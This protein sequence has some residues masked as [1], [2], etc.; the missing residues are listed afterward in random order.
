MSTKISKK[1]V[2]QGQKQAK[3]H[4]HNEITSLRQQ[5]AEFPKN[6]SKV[7]KLN[8]LRTS[9]GIFKHHGRNTYKIRFK[10]GGGVT[11]TQQLTIVAHTARQYGSGE[12]HLT[13]RQEIEILNIPLENTPGALE[14]LQKHGLDISRHDNNILNITTSEDAGT[15]YQEKFDTIPHVLTLNRILNNKSES[16]LSPI[17]LRIGFASDYRDNS[18]ARYND[19]GFIATTREGK[20]GF[21]VFIGGVSGSS[22]AA[23]Y[24]LSGF[25]EEKEILYVIETVKRIIQDNNELV[26]RNGTNLRSVIDALGREKAFKLFASNYLKIRGEKNNRLNLKE[27]NSSATN[28]Q[29]TSNINYPL[30]SREWVYR[31]VR[32]QKQS[33]LF[34]VELPLNKGRISATNI[35]KLAGFLAPF[36]NDVIRLSIHQHLFLRNIPGVQLLPLQNLLKEIRLQ[37]NERNS[38]NPH[39]NGFNIPEPTRKTVN[40]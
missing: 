40:I 32:D 30:L 2:N 29:K 1:D 11:S 15:S 14:N 25:L 24:L 16:S 20:R 6:K 35:E 9:M 19:I 23:G 4:L 5:I 22:P 12:I 7:I 31:Y 8:A 17:K 3:Q 10:S 34:S 21:R 33:G 13:P 18:L 27:L 38:D 28:S 39:N 26:P 37:N 36:G